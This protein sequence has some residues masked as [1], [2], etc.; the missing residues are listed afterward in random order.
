M[1]SATGVQV[2]RNYGMM[3]NYCVT[4]IC[5]TGSVT[6]IQLYN[7]PLMG[8]GPV[9]EGALVLI[10]IFIN[11]NNYSNDFHQIIK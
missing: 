9:E 6:G 11:K 1:D 5:L 4:L 2:S 10:Q 7:G 3:S 8:G